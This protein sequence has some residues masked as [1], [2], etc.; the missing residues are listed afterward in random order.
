[1]VL[2]QLF[3]SSIL[4]PSIK[5]AIGGII[6]IGEKQAKRYLDDKQE[7]IQKRKEALQQSIG[8]EKY[9]IVKQVIQNAAKTI[10]Q[11]GK[12]FNLEDAFIQS[13]VLELIKDKTG[14]SDEEIYEIVKSIVLELYSYVRK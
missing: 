4:L 8:I 7:F 6:E 2:N 12:E 9:N 10:E 13:K 1:M 11:L 3:R 5:A 14:L